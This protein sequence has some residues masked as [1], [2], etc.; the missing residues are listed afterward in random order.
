MEKFKIQNVEIRKATAD[1]YE[2]LDEVLFESAMLHY[3]GRSD[4]FKKPKKSDPEIK[5]SFLEMLKKEESQVFV[6]TYKNQPIGTLRVLVLERK[7][8]PSMKSRKEGYI[9]ELV[10]KK[11]F[12]SQGVGK[13][14]I[15]KAYGWF[16]LQGN[17]KEVTLGVWG[18][19]KDALGFYKSLGFETRKHILSKI[20]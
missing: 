6:A 5:E 17:I 16:A 15:N 10:V 14:L 1:D 18:F 7:E 3:K 2:M 12:R 11:E 4:C 19:N 13:A 20:L 8:T 9:G